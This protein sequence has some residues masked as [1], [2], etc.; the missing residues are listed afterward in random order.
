LLDGR[1]IAIGA[2]EAHRFLEGNRRISDDSRDAE[3]VLRD[4]VECEGVE[5]GHV[6]R[7]ARCFDEFM[8]LADEL[9]EFE[10]VWGDAFGVGG[11]EFGDY[12]HGIRGN[13]GRAAVVHDVGPANEDEE[14]LF[15][16]I[17]KVLEEVAVFVPAGSFGS[18]RNPGLVPALGEVDD[19]VIGPAGFAGDS[20]FAEEVFHRT[21]DAGGDVADLEVL[22]T[23]H[24]DSIFFPGGA[25]VRIDAEAAV[26]GAG[27]F[28][29]EVG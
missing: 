27:S 1:E 29:G 2:V 14:A 21:Q 10:S 13:V 26:A 4:A 19:V 18:G 24:V 17:E 25:I 9:T 11:K 23:A 22:I 7:V 16:R 6:A 5:Q 3:E 12:G 28:G 8:A 20:V 15:G